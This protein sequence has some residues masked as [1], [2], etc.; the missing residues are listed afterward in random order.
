[1]EEFTEE[2]LRKKKE[3]GNLFDIFKVQHDINLD[4]T[5]RDNDNN[6]EFN[7]DNCISGYY[8]I[9]NNRI[10]ILE[11]ESCGTS[12]SLILQFIKKIIDLYGS[13]Y[14]VTDAST[15]HFQNETTNEIIDI[16]LKK[17][18]SLCYGNT[19]YSRY[20][21]DL[22]PLKYPEF[23]IKILDIIDF[24]D[25]TNCNE[26]IE[27]IKRNTSIKTI[28]EFFTFIKNDLKNITINPTE[29]FKVIKNKDWEKVITYKFIIY[30][31]YDFLEK[32]KNITINISP[33]TNEKKRKRKSSILPKTTS[34]NRK[35]TTLKKSRK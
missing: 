19:F 32:T 8:D 7:I 24:T 16:E 30:K 26:T 18:Y 3:I 14:S 11:V 20:L 12:I 15:F 35:T 21:S 2:V 25:Y 28:G 23:P 6:I 29:G 5:M 1:M 33:Q 4:I 10:Y 31:T 22:P 9:G 13:T 27:T 34:K 17:L